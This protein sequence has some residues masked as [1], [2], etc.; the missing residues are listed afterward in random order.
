MCA[1]ARDFN[2]IRVH[3]LR[4]RS[5]FGDILSGEMRFNKFSSPLVAAVIEK[6]AAHIVWNTMPEL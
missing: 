1:C 6:H 4:I 2:L 5:A 3:C